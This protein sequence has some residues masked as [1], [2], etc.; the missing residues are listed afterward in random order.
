MNN[1]SSARRARSSG[2]NNK[3]IE[4]TSNIHLAYE[5]TFEQVSSC[6]DKAILD[7]HWQC[8]HSSSQGIVLNPMYPWFWR[9][10]NL[11][12][13]LDH[14]FP[15]RSCFQCDL[16]HYWKIV[17]V[18]RKV[19]NSNKIDSCG[20]IAWIDDDFIRIVPTKLPSFGSVEAHSTFVVVE[21][22]VSH[23]ASMISVCP[24]SPPLCARPKSCLIS[25]ICTPP[26]L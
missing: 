16:H 20:T 3:L 2:P 23:V 15:M 6:K 1:E 7:S 9:I 18:W 21:T 14:L 24:S 13:H 19:G 5:S 10:Q 25:C 4:Q 8:S 26:C 22:W 17:W 11:A 12:N